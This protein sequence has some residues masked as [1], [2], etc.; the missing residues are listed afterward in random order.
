MNEIEYEAICMMPNSEHPFIVAT[1]ASKRANEI[2]NIFNQNK[3][4]HHLLTEALNELLKLF[5]FDIDKRVKNAKWMHNIGKYLCLN[6]Q[7]KYCKILFDGES[8]YTKCP[9]ILLH[10]DYGFSM[11]AIEE[12]V[13]SICGE[14]LLDCEHISGEIYHDIT[15]F[16]NSS[17]CNI[18]GSEWGNCNHK[19]GLKYNNVIGSKIVTNLEL[20]TF[21]M[22]KE[23]EEVFTRIVKIPYPKEYIEDIVKSQ[24]D[25]DDFV[26]GETT[27]F[28]SHCIECPG[29][30]PDRTSSIFERENNP[31]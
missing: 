19:E 2:L 23:P 14:D 26:Y 6:H 29:Y 24:G 17:L 3:N 11:R 31:T 15:C 10:Q 21:D 5:W 8:Y 28:C 4:A 25:Y 20:I 16:N 9:N 30:D 22:V 27:M 13:C 7:D 1:K 18:C 12:Y